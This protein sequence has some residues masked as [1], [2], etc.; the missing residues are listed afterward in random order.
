MSLETITKRVILGTLDEVEPFLRFT[1]ESQ[2]DF[3]TGWLPTLDTS[4]RVNGKNQIEF[5]FYEKPEAS[6]KTVQMKELGQARKKQ[7]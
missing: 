4:L 7:D 2:E 1:I 3:P 6:K 5:K